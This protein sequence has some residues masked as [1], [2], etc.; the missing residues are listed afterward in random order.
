MTNKRAPHLFPLAI[1][2]RKTM[3]R[4]TWTLFKQDLMAA[5]VVSL[6]ALPLS[7]ALSIAVGLPPQH[8]LYT[9]MVAGFI[10]PLL[11][12]SVHQVTG[13]TAAFVVILAPIVAEHGL[14]GIIWCGILAGFIL[15]V[16]G[17]SQF[18]KLVQ[19]IP[20][21]VTTGFTAGI[22]LVLATLSL[23]DFLGLHLVSLGH[24]YLDRLSA[25]IGALPQLNQQEFSVGGITLLLVI[26]SGHVV[27]F[28]PSAI[29][30]VVGGTLVA[31]FWNALGFDIATIGSRFSYLGT[32][33]LAHPGI[34][35]FLPV[36]H[37]PT[38]VPGELFS[39]PSIAEFQTLLF[40]ALAIA[41]LAALESLLSATVADSMAGTKHDPNAELTGVGVGNIFAALAMGIPATGAIARTA[42]NITNGAKTPLAVSMHAILILLYVLLFSTYINQIP[43]AAL[44]ALLIFTA[45]RMSHVRQFIHVL[46][47]APRSDIVVM[48]TCFFLT[49]FIDMVAGISLGMICAAFLLMKQVTEITQVEFEEADDISPK[50]YKI[51]VGTLMYRISGPLFFGSVEKA[52]DRSTFPQKQIHTVILDIAHVPFIDMSGLIALNSTLSA[53]FKAKYRILIVCNTQKVIASIKKNVESEQIKK[54]IQFLATTEEALQLAKEVVIQ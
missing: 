30:A 39:I 34:P 52:F 48:L 35:N 50:K 47:V 3:H 14:R 12:G 29:L 2:L 9:A 21:P 49:V 15:I 25:I 5:F 11:G 18:G 53:L 37:W 41:I 36:L 27:K 54:H 1:A 51:P 46:K 28:L 32:D 6:V 22:G 23:N 13:P 42:T 24:T 45:Y 16:L 10:V 33:G 26:Y 4:Y 7:M 19:Y 38:F 44:A 17:V 20:Y 40:P 8:G 31:Y 43:M